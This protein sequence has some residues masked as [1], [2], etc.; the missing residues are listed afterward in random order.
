VQNDH[1][2]LHEVAGVFQQILKAFLVLNIGHY[3]N[4]LNKLIKA[5]KTNTTEYCVYDYQG[6]RIRTV[7]EANNQAQSQRDYLPSLDISTK[8]AKQQTR[9]SNVRN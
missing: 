7:I 9:G 4:T 5:D 1:A 8:Q 3:N 2:Y 6:R